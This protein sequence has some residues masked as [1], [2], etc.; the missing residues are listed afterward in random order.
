MIHTR[1]G[2]LFG[3]GSLIAAPAVVRAESLMKISGLIIPEVKIYSAPEVIYGSGLRLDLANLIY[4]I[5][6]TDTPFFNRDWHGGS[7]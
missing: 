2:L 7:V 4:R 3:L 6:P 5:E 1:R